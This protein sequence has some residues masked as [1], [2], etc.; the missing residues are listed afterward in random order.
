MNNEKQTKIQKKV[1]HRQT[2]IHQLLKQKKLQI[3]I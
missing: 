1:A 3:E 2:I